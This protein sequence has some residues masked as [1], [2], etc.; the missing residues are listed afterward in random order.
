[1]SS[2]SISGT[3]SATAA[4][5]SATASSSA[6]AGPS[7]P[8]PPQTSGP[9]PPTTAI[10]GLVPSPIPDIPICLALAVLFVI[11]AVINMTIYQ[12]NR[13]E[14]YK[15]IFPIFIFFF[16]MARTAALV[17]R[18]VWASHRTD[19]RL[20]MVSQIFT[21]AG[22]MLLFVTNWM[23]VQTALRSS[24][25]LFGWSKG[26]T[27]ILRGL[28]GSA[29]LV[30]MM[31]I[32]ATVQAAF[33]PPPQPGGGD[34]AAEAAKTLRA[35]RTVQLMCGTYLA[36]YAVLPIPLIAVASLARRGSHNV[37]KFGEGDSR[38]KFGLLIFTASLLSVGAFFR[39]II[40]FFPR[41]V[42]DP[43]WY[44][45]K[46][47]YYCFNYVI[48]L[49]VVYTYT[50]SRFDRLFYVPSGCKAPGH[51]SRRS[52]VEVAAGR[53]TRGE[54]TVHQGVVTSNGQ[55]QPTQSL[56]LQQGDEGRSTEDENG[57]FPVVGGATVDGGKPKSRKE[58][59]IARTRSLFNLRK[60]FQWQNDSFIYVE[61]PDIDD[62]GRRHLMVALKIMTSGDEAEIE[63]FKKEGGGYMGQF[64]VCSGDFG[65]ESSS[66]QGPDGETVV[67][68]DDWV[69]AV[70]EVAKHDEEEHE[71]Y[72]QAARAALRKYESEDAT[73]G[74]WV[75]VGRK[76]KQG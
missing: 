38:T 47:C 13:K 2:S 42:S 15:F 17:L 34:D 32:V 6:P 49:V 65:Y 59:V 74:V 70:E 69:D 16:C 37:D 58:R 56:G 27:G 73:E 43:A 72:K 30:L 64:H 45:S 66:R 25:P 53:V 61:P 21:A 68:W 19:V 14:S 67:N 44:H 35:D 40:A 41:P 4:T 54:V 46:V 18:V 55:G 22:V 20:G 1:M 62:I 29:V 7:S 52:L 5:A 28:Y 31:V 8:A 33:V 12:R 11:G 63:Q 39:A 48:E 36:I 75:R 26:A 60:L 24:Y 71:R 3:L 51:Y 50:I 9:Y 76:A 10:L 23:F 57:E